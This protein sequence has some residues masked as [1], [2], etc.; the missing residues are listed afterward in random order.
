MT[1][2]TTFRTGTAYTHRWA[3]RFTVTKRTAKFVTLTD[4]HDGTVRVGV[5][6]HDGVEYC[7]PDGVYS[8]CPV[9]HA[10]QPATF[11]KVTIADRFGVGSTTVA[12]VTD[13]DR[14]QARRLL[15]DGDWVT[16]AWIVDT[17]D[18][19]GRYIRHERHFEPELGAAVRRA[20]ASRARLAVVR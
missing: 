16:R 9:L 8:Q 6:V 10:D 1:T 15:A 5:K 19:G 17:R 12:L 2:P 4:Q 11:T 18:N 20:E 13:R 3:G 7:Y 14:A